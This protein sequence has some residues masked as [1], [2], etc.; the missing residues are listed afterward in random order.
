MSSHHTL[1]LHTEVIHEKAARVA[2][3][4]FFFVAVTALGA[5]VRVP[6]KGTPV[7][8]TLQTFFVILS[9]AVLGRRSGAAS[10][11]I[12][13]TLGML[14]IPLFS[15]YASGIAHLSGPTGGYIVGFILA[16]LIVGYL[17][18][19]S[20]HNKFGIFLAFAVGMLTVLVCGSA[21]LSVVLSISLK[22]AFTIGFLPFLPGDCVK[23][24][25]A[26]TIFLRIAPR[27]R[28]IFLA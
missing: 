23:T 7:P 9:G 17:T 16:S 24:L 26:Y 20:Y 2:L 18:E 19:K 6:I 13:G 3:G 22:H 25:L 12:Y 28:A 8:I 5:Y 10:Q 21:W 4:I 27:A 15:G 14:G 11:L 1:V